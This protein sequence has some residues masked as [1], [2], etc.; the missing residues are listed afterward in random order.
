MRNTHDLVG[1]VLEVEDARQSDARSCSA[2]LA[3][4]HR[5][6]QFEGIAPL[7]TE[8]LPW[9]CRIYN[10]SG[11]SVI[12]GSMPAINCQW[13]DIPGAVRA[14]INAWEQQIINLQTWVPPASSPVSTPP[15]LPAIE[16]PIDGVTLQAIPLWE[17]NT[18]VGGLT[19]IYPETS[20]LNDTAGRPGGLIREPVAVW[21]CSVEHLR[22][23][24]AQRPQIA[25]VEAVAQIAS[26]SNRLR[27]MQQRLTH[28]TLFYDIGQKLTSNLNL[29]EVLQET[30]VLAARVLDADAS[31]LMLVDEKTQELI[32]EIP[33][34]TAGGMLRQQRI[35]LTQGIAGWV[36]T[37]HEAILCND[38]ASD[39]RFN[40]QVDAMTGFVTRSVLCVPLQVKGRIIGVLEV[41]N[42]RQ[43]SG[44]NQQDMEWLGTLGAQ[45]AIAIENARLYEVLRQ[46]Q[47]RILRVQEQERHI[48]AQALHDGPTATLG[49]MVMGLDMAQRLARS[50][51]ERLE[52]ELARLTRL[53]REAYR[54]LRQKLFELRPV[55]LR[56][57][58]LFAALQFYATQLQDMIQFKL[59]LDLPKSPPELIPDAAEAV[60]V[61]IQE[62]INN[63][64][65]HAQAT[66]CWLRIRV[67][68]QTQKLVVEIEDDGRGFDVS[69]VERGYEERGSLG[70]I[71]MHERAR[72]LGASLALISPRPDR[73][74]GSLVRL[75]IPLDRLVAQ[76]RS[77]GEISSS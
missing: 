53:A 69:G 40:S 16:S 47:E 63:V 19:F 73:P 48:L 44:F 36:A 68:E 17:D 29:P 13:G 43:P 50:K 76:A 62:A 31:T 35:P 71:G 7:W 21:Q 22:P 39:P 67:N 24:V 59:H 66:N 75:E 58:G 5:I 25:L 14:A 34:G 41:L 61:V 45:A 10:A 28:L 23:Q 26:L 70:L 72:S 12:Y 46:E 15:P 42:K 38:V 64:S 51:P 1:P 8:A 3:R 33:V 49:V 74:N 65:K 60:F 27:T 57:R 52:E 32:F 37:H 9:L 11:A 6:G 77:Q 56:T 18:L 55:I 20:S 54:A 2:F 4:L 30:T